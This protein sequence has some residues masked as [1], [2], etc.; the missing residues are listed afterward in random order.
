MENSSPLQD[1]EHRAYQ[2]AYS[3]GLIDLFVGISLAW[4]GVAWIWLP[5]LAAL[6]G[7]FPAVFAPVVIAT[8][9]SFVED[10][11]GYVRWSEPRRNRE[12]RTLRLAL[13]FGVVI[14][15]CGVV[16]YF[17]F[18]S[19][20][21]GG[22]TDFVAPALLAWILAFVAIQLAY[23]LDAWRFLV[24]AVVLAVAGLVTAIESANPG[25]PLLAVGT[26][27]TIAGT[28]MLVRFVIS[29]PKEPAA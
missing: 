4:I 12:Q 3:D 13:L 23:V 16:A 24:Y 14:F 6:A 7:I 26:V 5:D 27:M 21:T 2:R 18:E 8:R 25:A 1:L 22:V 10:R 28:M 19:S 11:A 9:K 20:P 29:N 15:L 17:A